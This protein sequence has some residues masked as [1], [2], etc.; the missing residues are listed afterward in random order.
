MGITKH[1]W[2]RLSLSFHINVMIKMMRLFNDYITNIAVNTGYDDPIKD[3]DMVLS[4]LISHSGH[5]SIKTI[6][7]FMQSVDTNSTLHS[8]NIDVNVIGSFL[9]KLKCN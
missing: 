7:E 5:D 1:F 9:N 4:Y 2:N 6:K 3:D 8:H